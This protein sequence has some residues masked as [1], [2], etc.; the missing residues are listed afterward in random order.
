MEVKQANIT[1]KVNKSWAKNKTI[2]LSRYNNEKWND[3]DTKYLETIGDYNYYTATT[4]GFSYFAIITEENKQEIIEETIELIK[5]QEKPI[6]DVV[7]KAGKINEI[8]E[9]TKETKKKTNRLLYIIIIL[10]IGIIIYLINHY[11]KE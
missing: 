4:P 9:G 1:F 3:L 8:E 5:E 2:I 6:E 10:A 11:Q 7:E